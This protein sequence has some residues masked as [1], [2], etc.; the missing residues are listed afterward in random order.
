MPPQPW[1]QC[2]HQHRA[3]GIRCA[4]TRTG[5]WRQPARSSPQW[6]TCPRSGSGCAAL[7]AAA[8]PLPGAPEHLP[9]A[10][11]LFPGAPELFRREL[12]ESE[13]ELGLSRREPELF[14]REPEAFRRE[15][16]LLRRKLF[17]LSSPPE[18]LPPPPEGQKSSILSQ[19]RRVRGWR[20]GRNANAGGVC[21]CKQGGG[22]QSSEL[23]AQSS[24]LK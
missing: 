6:R 1:P 4:S 24:E 2:R 7:P 11:M 23:K 17:L 12:E 13:R 8:D 15:P 10:K 19:N 14:R 18:T 22:G 9:A 16:G 5:G 21:L 3:P 20:A